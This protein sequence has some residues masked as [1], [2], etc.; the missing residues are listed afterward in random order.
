L[1]EEKKTRYSAEGHP[2]VSTGAPV[3]ESFYSKQL[4]QTPFNLE[5]V[6]FIQDFLA[7]REPL[8]EDQCYKLSLQRETR[9]P[10][11]SPISWIIFV[12]IHQCNRKRKRRKGSHKKKEFI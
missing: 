11:R 4:M 5:E 7:K 6:P 8:P 1:G 2:T 9:A 12:L 3:I 10:G